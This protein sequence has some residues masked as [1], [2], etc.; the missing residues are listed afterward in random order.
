MMGKGELSS[1]EAGHAGPVADDLAFDQED[2]DTYYDDIHGTALRS[3]LVQAARQEELTWIKQ[4]KIYTKVPLRQCKQRTGK[5]PLDTRWID[6][7]KGDDKRPNY[8]SRMVVREIKARKKLA[9]QLPGSQLFSATPP[10]ET[11]FLLASLMMS[12]KVSTR[13]K[14]LKLG[15][16]DISR[17]HF[18]EETTRELYIRIPEEDR[19]PNDAEE[20]CGILLR[21]MY[22]T[23]DASN[24]FQRGYVELLSNHGYVF[25]KASFATFFKQSADSRGLVHGDDFAVLADEDG[26]KEMDQL[27]NSKYTAKWL[28]TVGSEPGDDKE[29]LFLNRVVRYCPADEH[30]EDRLEIEADSRH[31]QRIIADLGLQ[32]AKSVD[33]PAVKRTAAEVEATKRE[34][35][36]AQKVQTLFRS[37]TMRGAYLS[38][39]RPD[40]GDAVKALATAM[41]TPKESDMQRLR[42]FGR[43]LVGVPNLM[44][45]FYKQKLP[46]GVTMYGDSDWAGDL[47]S[48]K[49]TSGIACMH[50]R[51]LVTA[52]CNLQSVTSLSSCEAE[53]YAAVKALAHALFIRSV[54]VD[55]GLEGSTIDL[56]TDSSSAK[57]FI[58]RRGLGKNRHIQTKWLWIQERMA[59]QD[60]IL[61]KV[62]TD[63]SLADLMTKALSGSVIR[64]HLASM[65]V[66]LCLVESTKQ[67]AVL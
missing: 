43:Y 47:L 61:K 49:S 14:P 4:E 65:N 23:Q 45:V 56:L 35:V 9:E 3:D 63:K 52:K 62:G 12:I 7:N 64:K 29:A 18:M 31:A 10:V 60:F 44:R 25:G 53:F 46:K 38:I 41:K 51:H 27:L 17:A 13:G 8:R 37:N 39:D 21:T 54:L 42:R 19:D 20:M 5:Q 22:G 58:E 50:G 30:G 24:L 57:C 11:F 2:W 33:T 32:N 26:L 66:R 48:R 36:V 34:P 40:L 1:F 6:H 67:R 28:A 59:A 15:F 16:W 55:W